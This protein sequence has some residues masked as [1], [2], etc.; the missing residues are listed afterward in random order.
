MYILYPLVDNEDRGLK[1][2]LTERTGAQ[3]GEPHHSTVCKCA[4]TS[5][6]CPSRP[7]LDAYLVF[8]V[9]EGQVCSLASSGDSQGQTSGQA[10]CP[11]NILDDFACT[12]WAFPRRQHYRASNALEPPPIWGVLKHDDFTLHRAV[13]RVLRHCHQVVTKRHCL[14][15]GRRG[16]AGRDKGAPL[17]PN[18]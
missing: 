4:R 10:E 16:N 15:A 6:C 13:M 14:G 11:A 3:H 2:L 17:K 18:R 7:A 5:P 1:N 9:V 8:Y 12:P